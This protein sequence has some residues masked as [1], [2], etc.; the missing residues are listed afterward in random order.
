MSAIFGVGDRVTEGNR[1]GTVVAL[2]PAGMV[3]VQFRDVT[4]IERRPGGALAGVPGQVRANPRRTALVAAERLVPMPVVLGK[5]RRPKK[6]KPT[7]AQLVAAERRA[8]TLRAKPPEAPELEPW[9]RMAHAVYESLIER[10]Y[11]DNRE[12]MSRAFAI[13]SSRGQKIGWF[14]PGTR[15]P[16]PKV[17]ARA[18]EMLAEKG[19][20]LKAQAYEYMLARGRKYIP[21]RILK[22]RG[23][24]VVEPTGR[25]FKTEAGALRYIERTGKAPVKAERKV[26]AA[27]KRLR[28]KER[29]LGR[30]PR[31]RTNAEPIR[32]LEK[33]V[34]VYNY[35]DPSLHGVITEILT[36]KACMVRWKGRTLDSVVLCRDI[37]PLRAN[38]REPVRMFY[39]VKDDVFVL[40]GP[41]RRIRKAFIGKGW[42]R[43][44]KGPYAYVPGTAVFVT[45]NER[46]ARETAAAM[47]LSIQG[48]SAS[49]RI[50]APVL[51]KRLPAR[52]GYG[53]TPRA[54]TAAERK[55]LEEQIALR[56]RRNRK[57][58]RRA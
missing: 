45:D 21:F 9:R 50:T 53:P 24:F 22:A 34:E 38:Q 52:M 44:F 18:K 15:A 1:T 55:A 5:P 2:R 31:A 56:L 48:L 29:A 54:A 4:H 11:P 7:R 37:L 49:K 36:R 8:L 12:T 43:Q 41:P 19:A 42:K 14:E 6:R 39:V 30:R 13:A 46:R 23:G 58:K 28:V 40:M 32:Y 47:G 16:T 17:K 20:P 25:F 3:D 35:H 33:G 26:R 27:T 57:R 10:G 51:P